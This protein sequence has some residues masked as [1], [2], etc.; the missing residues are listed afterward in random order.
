MCEKALRQKSLSQE[1]LADEL[2]DERRHVQQLKREQ[3]QWEEARFDELRVNKQMWADAQ[4]SN[5][6]ELKKR[7]VATSPICHISPSPFTQI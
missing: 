4:R 1:R 6:M 5:L 3:T 2:A 7:C